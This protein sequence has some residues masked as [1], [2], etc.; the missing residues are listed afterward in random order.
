M[1]H[2]SRTHLHSKHSYLE[3]VDLLW[4]A[5][6]PDVLWLCGHTDVNSDLKVVLLLANEGLVSC[7]VVE[8]FICVHVVGRWRPVKDITPPSG[9]HRETTADW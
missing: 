3:M 4:S 5:G 9:G 6:C 2:L 1:V 7:R 8:A